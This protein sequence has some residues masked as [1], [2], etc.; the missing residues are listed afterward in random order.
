MPPVP[1]PEPGSP[2]P[3]GATPDAHGVNFALYSAVAERVELC[4]FDAQGERETA[5]FALA[6]PSD[7]VWHGQVPGLA[8]GARYGYRVHGPYQPAHGLRCN[9]HKLLL[10]PYARAFDGPL[11]LRDEHCG[12]TPGDPAADL[13]FDR[14]DSAP[15]TPKAVVCAPEAPA[16]DTRPRTP[17]ADTLLYEAHVRGFT[18]R[19]PALPQAARGRFEGL[20]HAAVIDW[21]RALGVTAVELLPVHAYT[22]ERALL[23][24]G[25]VNYW[26]YNTFGFFA[27]HLDYGT[28]TSL[29]AMVRALHEA[30][31]EVIL[32][33]VYNHTAESDELGPTCL[34]RGIDNRS[35]Y[36]L[37]GEG[38]YYVNDT[39]CGNTLNFSHPRVVQLAADS[40]RHWAESFGVDGFRFDLATVLAREDH[41]FDAGA[42]L[43]DVLAQDPL[44]GRLKLIAEPWDIGPGG[45]RLGQFPPGW[46]EWN[47]RYR[48]C[49]RRYWRGDPGLLAE[50]AQRLH[51]SSESFQ[52][53]GRAPSASVNFV[54]SHDGFTLADLVSYATRHNLANGEDGRDGHSDNLSDNHG[55]EGPSD[56]P[57]VDAAR[58]RTRLNL[59]ATL[60]LAQ[61]TPMLL[62]GDEF[63]HSQ[64]GNNNAY[65]QDN[66]T[67]WLDW[68]RAEA[69][70][71]FTAALR[72]LVALRRDCAALRGA[73]YLHGVRAPQRPGPGQLR[74]LAPSGHDMTHADWHQ[75]AAR[76][77]GLWLGAGDD[78]SELVLLFNAGAACDFRLP[79][80]ADGGW[81]CAFDSA[82]PGADPAPAHGA[83]ALAARS[84]RV[85]Q[86]D[87]HASGPT[88]RST[89]GEHQ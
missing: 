21:L 23:R 30:G 31:I 77:L 38:R 79:A 52:A 45:Y 10:D 39:G 28:A 35:Y 85:L 54:T 72:R 76:A 18:L 82:E 12:Y 64:G 19:H 1:V 36:R 60:L 69:E 59:L 7:G 41:G 51:G 68:T 84:V 33:V 70:A 75:P 58:L 56:D 78:G 6:G 15:F 11:L 24:R 80:E 83:V 50:L 34:F 20:A 89:K 81:S 29:R 86:R 48:D 40:L 5:R 49:V 32:D 66:A 17:W 62:A 9:P 47:D 46:R 74:W 65:C 27:P 3:L 87:V 8:A 26:G 13:G 22:H 2:W 16:A 42:G 14:R 88:T 43:L 61:G 73:R 71:A 63:G 57:A 53:A 37:Q 44:L 4:L 55:V 67:T 25:L